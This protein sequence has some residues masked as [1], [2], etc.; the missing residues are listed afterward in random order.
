MVQPCG[1]GT[2][3][4]ATGVAMGL[5]PPPG[6]G[7][8]P[9]DFTASHN[10]VCSGPSTAQRASSCAPNL[11]RHSAYLRVCSTR[12]GHP[13]RKAGRFTGADFP[14]QPDGTLRCPA[15]QSLRV[16]EH[17]Q[18]VDGSLRVVYAA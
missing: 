13:P 1:L 4:L 7:S 9:A 6:T 18:E 16:Q 14:L 3:V 5:E 15:G 8:S 11:L 10:G 2:G 12:Y 17:R